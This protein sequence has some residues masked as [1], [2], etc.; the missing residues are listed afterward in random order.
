MDEDIARVELMRHYNAK[1]ES[2]IKNIYAV[3]ALI[4]GIFFSD[5]LNYLPAPLSFNISEIVMVF[6]PLLLYFTIRARYYSAV[7]WA[8]MF[9][10]PLNLGERAQYQEDQL[11][12]ANPIGEL[13]YA[14]NDYMKAQNEKLLGIFPV[15]WN[16]DSHFK[17]KTAIITP[18]LF[19]FFGVFEW[20][21]LVW[22]ANQL[23]SI[24]SCLAV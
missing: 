9:I 17:Y 3:F 24:A 7:L 21:P 2:H 18:I 11:F 15:K 6:L 22:I 14:C 13:N 20:D 23:L 5:R 1:N 10:R 19:I 8:I 16:F 12:K 4:F